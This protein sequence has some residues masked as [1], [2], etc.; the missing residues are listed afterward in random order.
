MDRLDPFH[1]TTE[2]VW[3]FVP[4]TVNVKAGPPASS[5]VGAV[6]VAVGAGLPMVNV[7]APEAPPPGEGFDTVTLAVPGVVTSAA[8]TV[9]VSFELLTKAVVRPVPFHNTVAPLTKLPPFTVN[10]NLA[11]PAITVDGDREVALGTGLL[12]AKA[13][14]GEDV[15][16]PGAGFAT[17]TAAVPV[18]AMSLAG[19]VAVSLMA[20]TNV[21][22]SAELFHCTVEVFTKFEP[23]TVSVKPAP[24]TMALVGERLAAAGTGLSIVNV[25][26]LDTLP[27]GIITVT[28]AVPARVRSPAGTVAVNCVALP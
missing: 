3:N 27:P 4:I 14:D 24:P 1:N 19:T 8:V 12:M 7:S 10:V 13:R 21:V 18:D 11:L 2:L 17:V 16:P 6:R 20:L 22:V 28:S 23:F 26:G 15:P 5:L 9:A 25:N